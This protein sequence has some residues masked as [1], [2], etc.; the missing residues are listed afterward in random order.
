MYKNE[1]LLFDLIYWYCRK[2]L[3]QLE[4]WDGS[5][6]LMNI[7]ETGM[8][9]IPIASKQNDPQKLLSLITQ[10]I[11]TEEEIDLQIKE[12]DLP[13]AK[14][15]LVRSPE[16]ILV[17]NLMRL[18]EEYGSRLTDELRLEVPDHWE[19]HGDLI[20]LPE[21]AFSSDGWKQFGMLCC[22]CLTSIVNS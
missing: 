12:M 22:Y 10:K 16:T 19:R 18:F 5:R 11:S 1:L 2:L 20:L 3:K 8:V 6:R 9:A 17:E 13:T 21:K 4:F 7:P 15:L 14:K